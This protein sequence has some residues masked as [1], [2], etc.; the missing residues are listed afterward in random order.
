MNIYERS[1]SLSFYL[2]HQNA[3]FQKNDI[4]TQQ[5]ATSVQEGMCENEFLCVFYGGSEMDWVS[6][7]GF[8]D[9][10][11]EDKGD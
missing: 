7:N 6:V 4:N 9:Y 10:S 5:A 11:R 8:Y 1:I 2:H 3:D